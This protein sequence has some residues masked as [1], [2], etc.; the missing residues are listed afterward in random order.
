MP[1]VN[2]GTNIFGA[3][4][5]GGV[6]GHGGGLNWTYRGSFGGGGTL[7]NVGFGNGNFFFSEGLAPLYKSTT[8]G[9]SWAL[10]HTFT[11][12]L[13][14]ATWG[15]GVWLVGGSVG[16]VGRSTNDGTTW[17]ELAPAA[18]GGNACTGL[19]TDG[20][21]HWVGLLTG[22]HGGVVTSADDGLTWTLQAFTNQA[23]F[24]G[25]IIWDGT[26]YVAVGL[27]TGTGFPTIY[28]SPNG[29]LWTPSTLDS[30][31]L[32]N[33]GAGISF[34]ALSGKYLLG[35]SSSD[36]VRIAATPAGLATAPP[37]PTF[38][39]GGGCIGS[40]AAHGKMFAFSFDGS[41]SDSIDGGATWKTGNTNFLP[42]HTV[43]S[44]AYN[45]VADIY[46]A[47][48]DA[49]DVSTLP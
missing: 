13:S 12:N 6:A 22:V 14:Q 46:V 41:T 1:F 18:F 2:G 26:Q 17:A 39:T 32:I 30:T 16:H 34:D 37:V 11:F 47:V 31:G 36:A 20:A 27:A 24:N 28:T 3:G 21:G 10:N 40:F 4:F 42:T 7:F 33:F 25:E 15:N 38:C 44:V 35:L 8:E 19:A 5:F 23:W 29:V 48:G 49:G 9:V 45:P 43:R